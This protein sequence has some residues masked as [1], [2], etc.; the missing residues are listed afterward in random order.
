[1]C[2]A[3][4]AGEGG[5][6]LLVG[7][8][9]AALQPLFPKDVKPCSAVGVGLFPALSGWGG[10]RVRCNLGR[11]LGRRPFKYGPP[12]GFH[13][14]STVVPAQDAACQVLACLSLSPESNPVDVHA[15]VGWSSGRAM[16]AYS[17]GS[18]GY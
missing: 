9:S 4:D 3:W 16:M 5:G 18:D 13:P 15:M 11:D 12:E 8:D 6:T 17:A 10:C 1:M 7:V 14:Y 2:V